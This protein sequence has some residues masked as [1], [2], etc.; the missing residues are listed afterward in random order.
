[1]VKQ[2]KVTF[3]KGKVKRSQVREVIEKDSFEKHLLS[4][5][6]ENY[7]TPSAAFT[8]NVLAQQIHRFLKESSKNAH[9]K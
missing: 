5:N 4:T 3:L 7:T 6:T 2:T 9:L 8:A 1:M